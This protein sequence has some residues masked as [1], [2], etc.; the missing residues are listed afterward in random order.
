MS[1]EKEPKFIRDLLPRN[2]LIPIAISRAIAKKLIGAIVHKDAFPPYLTAD[3]Q[4]E[5][6]VALT[7][8]LEE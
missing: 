2:D 5:L 7:R 4:D 3:E 8:A 6:L 1:N